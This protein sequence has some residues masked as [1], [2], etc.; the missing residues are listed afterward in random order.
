VLPLT[1]LDQFAR[2]LIGQAGGYWRNTIREGDTTCRVCT[3][4]VDGYAR[5]F[6]CKE[7]H[8][9]FGAQLATATG[10]LT[11]AIRDTQS[12]YVMHG[13]KAGSDGV[14]EHKTLVALL[15]LVGIG[16]HTGCAG[17]LAG[18]PATHWATVPSLRGRPGPHP[19][20][21]LLLPATSGEEVPLTAGVIAIDPRSVDPRHF[22][23]PTL[24]G[25]RPHVLL[26]DDTWTSGGHVQ[27]AA[28]AL[29]AAGADVVSVLL[30]AR[31]LNPNPRSPLTGTFIRDRL[32]RDYNPA[33]C[34]W[35]GDVCP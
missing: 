20:R 3:T 29:R 10:F 4:P 22:I 26:L 24:Q 30:L 17:R 6:P 7:H 21:R 31:W 19:L 27:S 28:L 5:C 32:T 9:S 13:Y 14:E 12:G 34:P 33:A 23:S 35:T 16:R 2:L 25:P 15:G 18:T 11:Y 1:T 8:D